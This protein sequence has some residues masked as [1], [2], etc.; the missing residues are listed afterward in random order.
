MQAI[1][2]I[3]L[4]LILGYLGGLLGEKL[5]LTRVIGYILTGILLGPSIFRVLSRGVISTLIPVTV[6]ALCFIAFSIGMKLKLTELIK[7]ER[8][9]SITTIFQ[10]FA[11]FLSVSFFTFVFFF[12]FK[13]TEYLLAIS[14]LLGAIASATAPATVLAIVEEGRARGPF[15][16]LLLEVVALGDVLAIVLFSIVLV[17]AKAMVGQSFEF[18]LELLYPLFVELAVTVLLGVAIGGVAALLRKIIKDFRGYATVVVSAILFCFWI[19]EFF[20]LSPLLIAMLIGFMVINY[21]DVGD[22]VF[23]LTEHIEKPL[24]IIFFV[25]AGASLSFGLAWRLWLTL[26]RDG[27]EK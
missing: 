4:I 14:L 27:W 10:F 13:I 12:C 20:S 15:A 7:A 17:I 22:R 16:S 18:G 8:L 19:A 21:T 3:G 5:K 9:V 26:W 6:L 1:F 11:T 2:A 23:E 24:F 25:V